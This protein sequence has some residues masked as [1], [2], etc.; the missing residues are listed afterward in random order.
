MSF[1][2]H[3]Q[4]GPDS[5]ICHLLSLFIDWQLHYARR[6]CDGSAG[7][8]ISKRVNNSMAHVLMTDLF[9]ESG[10][11]CARLKHCFTGSTSQLVARWRTG[12]IV[13]RQQ[14]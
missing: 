5:R 11:V 10:D 7:E 2:R 13:T 14:W 12:D 9:G 3:R 4:E 6:W 8:V 1:H